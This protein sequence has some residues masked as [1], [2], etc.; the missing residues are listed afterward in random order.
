[1]NKNTWREDLASLAIER[2]EICIS[3]IMP[4]HFLSP[5]RRTEPSQLETKFK[6]VKSYLSDKYNND[7]VSPLMTDMKA[8]YEQ[9]DFTRNTA[10][11]GLFVS[12]NVKKLVH[13]FFPVKERFVIARSF[14]LRDLLYESYY[15]IPYVVLML[16][17]KE[18]RLF[19]A[20]LDILSEVTGDHFPKK[21]EAVYEYARPSRGNSY[22]GQS[23][24][25]EFEK[26]KS[27]TEEIRLKSFFRETDEVLDSYLD[28]DTPLIVIGDQKELAWF[29]QVTT[30]EHNIACNIPGN[31]M[32]N[33]EHEL[34]L[35]TW[36][37]MK[38][39]YKKNKEKLIN[40]FRE[41][42]RTT[43]GIPGVEIENIWRAVHEG[44]GYKLLVEKDLTFTGYVSN[45]DENELY[46]S[47]PKH[48]NHEVAD[49]INR[50]IEVML[51]KNGEVIIMDN[52]MLKEFMGLALITR[53]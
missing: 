36:K 32:R 20:H 16:S 21:N 25:K 29:R 30:H 46:R 52:G 38:L 51:E 2:D 23:N 3:I 35:L 9:I 44:R 11:I 47:T 39:F 50:L 5:D 27:V 37:A 53:Y 13:F 41:M 22:V 43:R 48:P 7:I 6:E 26:D 45:D 19:N 40:E 12:K 33:N 18:A 24:L 10:G 4:G 14:D 17:Q 31:Y 42:K 1:M 34:S 8:L 49:V 28:L 15:N